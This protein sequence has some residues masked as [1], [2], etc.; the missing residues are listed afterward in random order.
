LEAISQT[1]ILGV[2]LLALTGCRRGEIEK[3]HW[4]E[5]DLPGRCLRLAD[6][7]EGKSVRPLGSDAIGVLRTA[8]REGPYVL[9]GN[10][11]GKPFAGLPKAWKR[12]TKRNDLPDLTPHGLRHAFASVVADLGY[13]EP[14]IAAMLGHATRVP[15]AAISIIWTAL[16]A[17]A[18]KVTAAIA[19]MMNGAFAGASPLSPL[20]DRHSP[21]CRSEF[22]G[23]TGWRGARFVTFNV[24]ASMLLLS[25]TQFSYVS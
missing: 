2:R 15:L 1:A 3:L 10:S 16:V 20:T 24:D 18:D 13:T 25:I 5:V 12:I 21:M 7:K 8:S 4:A 9:P 19:A 6:T 11:H 23:S 22:S 17:A 14:T